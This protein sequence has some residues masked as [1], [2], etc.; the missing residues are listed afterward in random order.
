MRPKKPRRY[1]D[2]SEILTV[3]EEELERRVA[4]HPEFT[5]EAAGD[6][7]DIVLECFDEIRERFGLG[8]EELAA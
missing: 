8:Q 4:E 7:N 1:Q 5:H 6:F 2:A 3:L